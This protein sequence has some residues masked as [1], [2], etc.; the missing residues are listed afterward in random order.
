MVWAGLSLVLG[1]A[2]K[3][4]V[5]LQSKIICIMPV[6]KKIDT[7]GNSTDET[8]SLLVG[9]Y[10]NSDVEGNEKTNNILH[11]GERYNDESDDSETSQDLL[12]ASLNKEKNN[13]GEEEELLSVWTITC[14]LSSSFAY[15]CI[16]TTLFLITLP[17][18]CE[19]IEK[20]IPSVP[21]SVRSIEHKKIMNRE[22]SKSAESIQRLSVFFTISFR[23]V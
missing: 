2:E 17:I 1:V 5:S 10:G 9:G 12:R 15:G 3:S 7:I 14:I 4:E 13:S 6:E 11:Y 16:M 22:P 8:S 21:K 23:C 18:E 19:R 20:Q